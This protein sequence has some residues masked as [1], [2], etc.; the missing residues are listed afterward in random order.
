LCDNGQDAQGSVEGLDRSA[1]GS[2]V[3]G[4]RA[5]TL[6]FFRCFHSIPLAAAGRNRHSENEKDFRKLIGEILWK[7]ERVIKTME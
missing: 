1:V 4:A 7:T 2:D 5:A 6:A 3:E